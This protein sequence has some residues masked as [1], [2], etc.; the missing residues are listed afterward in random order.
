M[1]IRS[2]TYSEA[3]SGQHRHYHNDEQLLY[4]TEGRARVQAEG[5]EYLAAAGSL[6]LFSRHERHA[7]EVEGAVYKRYS[8]RLES[9]PTD[10]DFLYSVLVNRGGCFRHV[11]EAPALE[12]Y[13]SAL[14][15]EWREGS[16]LTERMRQLLLQ[17]LF[18][19]L[20]RQE[21]SL[22][23]AEAA[24]SMQQVRRDIE[25][26]YAAPLTLGA[27]AARH[28][29]SGSRLSHS[30]KEVCGYAPMEYLFLCRMTAAQRML[31]ETDC[32]IGEVVEACGFSDCSNFGRAFKRRMGCSPS[33]FRKKY[34]KT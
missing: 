13:F 25:E 10:R 14:E 31:A 23:A 17:E 21:P 1:K 19:A 26:H 18:I 29:I 3:L 32:P 8:V 11:V 34:Q 30:F 2:V 7:V 6:V 9:E 5:R 15:R 24:D 4:I 20:Y 16:A 22:F 27:L 12:P 28:H 33:E